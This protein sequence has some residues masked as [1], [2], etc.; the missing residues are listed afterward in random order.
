MSI[1]I[2]ASKRSRTEGVSLSA[3]APT[4]TQGRPVCEVIYLQEE[5]YLAAIPSNKLTPNAAVKACSWDHSFSVATYMLH[6]VTD[7]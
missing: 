5:S 7:S 3:L 1:K 4:T 2:S 6:T